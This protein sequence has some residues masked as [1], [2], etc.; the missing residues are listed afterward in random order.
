ME[1]KMQTIK[2]NNGV[3]MPILDCVVFQIAPENCEKTVLDA[4]RIDYR[5][6][7]TVQAYYK[8]ARGRKCHHEVWL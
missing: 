2:L 4:T 5:S 6:I 8:R 3:E 1:N 7:D